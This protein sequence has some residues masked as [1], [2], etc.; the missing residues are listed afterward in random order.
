VKL[1]QY[2]RRLE[3]DI[4]YQAAVRELKPILDLADDILRLRLE[5]RWSQS[6]LARRAGTKQANISRLEAGLGNPTVR[7]IQRVAQALDVELAIL[8]RRRP[9]VMHE[10]GELA[11]QYFSRH[12]RIAS[13]GTS[14][15]E[16]KPGEVSFANPPYQVPSSMERP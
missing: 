8:L 9:S 10:M 11:E 7:F 12:V 16:D 6:E 3:S 4:E 5:R 2:R 15:S 13:S 1:E 14:G